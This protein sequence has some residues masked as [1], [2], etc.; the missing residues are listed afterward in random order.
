MDRYTS[1]SSNTRALAPIDFVL[2]AVSDVGIGRR[3]VILGQS[4][5]SHLPGQ[6][7]LLV[8]LPFPLQLDPLQEPLAELQVLVFRV[9]RQPREETSLGAIHQIFQEVEVGDA[10]GAYPPA[11][12]PHSHQNNMLL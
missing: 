3:K 5:I 1:R 9:D 4:S 8:P 6:K 10:N 2:D 7:R 11:E 12:I